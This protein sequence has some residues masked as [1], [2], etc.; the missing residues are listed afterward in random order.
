MKSL[1]LIVVACFGC[2]YGWTQQNHF[3]EAERSFL[4]GDYYTAAQ[5][6]RAYLGLD[7]SANKKSYRPYFIQSTSKKNKQAAA[8]KAVAMYHLAESYRL[9]HDD[10]SAAVWYKKTNDAYPGKFPL[11]LYWYGVSERANEQYTLAEMALRQFMAGRKKHDRYEKDALQELVNLSFIQDELKQHGHRRLLVKKLD[12]LKNSSIPKSAATILNGNTLVFTAAFT[13]SA[14][15]QQHRDPYINRIYSSKVVNASWQS[16]D[17]FEFYTGNTTLQQG[18]ASFTPGGNRIFFTQW[19]KEKDKSAAIYYADKNV[20]GWTDPVKLK[21]INKE[22]FN[23]IQP[24][25]SNDGKYLFFA[26]DM[27]GGQGGYDI[28]YIPLNEGFDHVSPINAGTI[29][30]TASDEQSPYYAASKQLVFASKGFTGMG[31]YD[32]FM[33][34]G[35][36]GEFKIPVNMGYPINSS[37]D[38]LYFFPTDQKDLLSYAYFSSDRGSDCCLELFTAKRLPAQRS[39]SGSV[40]ECGSGNVLRNVQVYIEDAAT[41]TFIDSVQA[42]EQGR[43]LLHIEDRDS[44]LIIASSVSYIT[45]R[46]YAGIGSLLNGDVERSELEAPVICLKDT[47]AEQVSI[48]EKEKLIY[49]DFDRYELNADAKEKLDMVVAFMKQYPSATIDVGGYTDEKGSGEYNLALA[50]QRSKVAAAYMIGKGLPSERIHLKS[51]GKCCPV[52]AEKLANGE[53]DPDAR[54]RNR[55]VGF[56]V[57]H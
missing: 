8:E 40:T 6:Y 16:P 51:Y 1:S 48:I 13:D 38:E 12:G 41:G 17:I 21:G 47:L 25:V 45:E 24:S 2:L 34:S 53:D 23:S 32:L 55:R 30:N 26:S 9:Y 28:W 4:K 20:A 35:A 15:L 54:R 5:Q 44:I 7:D 3:N 52:A 56:T 50:M 49:F 31:G 33:A 14:A 37:R 29:V 18:M 19:A 11:N 57:R 10:R 46:V 43:Y 42:D 22:G 39:I 27:P 36:P